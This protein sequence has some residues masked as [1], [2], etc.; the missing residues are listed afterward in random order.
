MSIRAPRRRPV[1]LCTLPAKR[2]STTAVPIVANVERA[3]TVMATR[4]TPY[5]ITCA[6]RASNHLRCIIL[7]NRGNPASC[8]HAK[9]TPAMNMLH[10][11]KALWRKGVDR[12]HVT[13]C[14]PFTETAVS[15]KYFIDKIN[16]TREYFL[17]LYQGFHLKTK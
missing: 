15:A 6:N 9:D 7:S 4:A 10:A 14:H 17:N 12:M 5:P 2:V 11:K 3:S 8:T 16:F 1:V 13:V